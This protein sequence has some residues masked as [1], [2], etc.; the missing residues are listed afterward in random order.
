MKYFH[1]SNLRKTFF[2][3]YFLGGIGP[4]CPPVSSSDGVLISDCVVGASFDCI[5]TFEFGNANPKSIRMISNIVLSFKIFA[6]VFFL[7]KQIASSFTRFLER[8]AS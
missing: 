6:M 1:S 3:Y 4:D 8:S 7:A 5:F 2:N